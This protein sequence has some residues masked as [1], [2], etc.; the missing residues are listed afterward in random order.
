VIH[1][2]DYDLRKPGRNYDDLLAAI[3][4]LGAWAHPLKSAWVVETLLTAHQVRD[5]LL[6]HIDAN[7]GLL[8]TRLAGEAAWHGLV[9]DVAQWLRDRLGRATV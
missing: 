7:D 5:R 1:Q 4:A 8:V 6:Q 2:I 9:P 3:K